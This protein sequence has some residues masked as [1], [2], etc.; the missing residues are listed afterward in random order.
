MYF[1][2]QLGSNTQMAIIF[3]NKVF[4][5]ISNILKTDLL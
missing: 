1:I 3:Q 5:K 4:F 2:I